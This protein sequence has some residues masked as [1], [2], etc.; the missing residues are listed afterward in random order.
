MSIFSF[1]IYTLLVLT[2][3]DAVPNTIGVTTMPN[4]LHY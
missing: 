4:A 3:L 1:V 2:L